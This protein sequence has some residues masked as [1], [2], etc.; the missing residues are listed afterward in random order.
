MR[1]RCRKD[2]EKHPKNQIKVRGPQTHKTLDECSQ[3]E[4]PAARWQRIKR[5]R[6]SA[7]SQSQ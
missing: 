1:G 5:P 7:R 2:D 6:L 3:S 4:C